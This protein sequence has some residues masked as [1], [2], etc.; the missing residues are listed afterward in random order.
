MNFMKIIFCHASGSQLPSSNSS[1]KFQTDGTAELGSHLGF[2]PPQ[3]DLLCLQ[4]KYAFYTLARYTDLQLQIFT[5]YSRISN[6]TAPILKVI[7]PPSQFMLAIYFGS[8][9]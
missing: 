1:S 6:T 9:F 2:L 7:S 4:Y 3:Q 8:S 5:Y